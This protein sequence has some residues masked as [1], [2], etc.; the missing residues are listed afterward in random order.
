MV[1]A[2]RVGTTSRHEHCP[3]VYL[4]GA[5]QREPTAGPRAG[6]G[7]NFLTQ[8]GRAAC[9][10]AAGRGSHRVGASSSRKQSSLAEA[11]DGLGRGT[12]PAT[13]VVKLWLVSN[14]RTGHFSMEQVVPGFKASGQRGAG[15]LKLQRFRQLA[16][17][18]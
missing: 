17:C 4:A 10:F 5:P 1:H 13:S 11:V 14:E 12:L 7:A 15:S 18:V 6:T 9:R 8:Q 2:G 16:Y 3:R